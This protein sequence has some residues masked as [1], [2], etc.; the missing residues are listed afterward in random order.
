M[1]QISP[2]NEAIFCLWLQPL[3][4][5]SCPPR[6]YMLVR[7][8]RES[9]W[10]HNR[11]GGMWVRR[12]HSYSIFNDQLSLS[13]SLS[14]SAMPNSSLKK[15]LLEYTQASNEIQFLINLW[16]VCFTRRSKEFSSQII[17]VSSKPRVHYSL[18]LSLTLKQFWPPKN[19]Y[20]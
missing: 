18:P 16:N 14:Y 12:F 11:P 8:S 5:I 1:K 13:F 17:Q 20:S 4:P 10:G 9:S 3:F 6:L 15:L 2:L 19:N 7:R